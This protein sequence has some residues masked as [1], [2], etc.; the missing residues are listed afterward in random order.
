MF[1]L[2]V[3]RGL[4]R[5]KKNQIPHQLPGLWY[6]ALAGGPAGDLDFHIFP[7]IISEAEK[8][9]TKFSCGY[10]MEEKP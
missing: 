9:A 8:E 2:W 3:S 5:M 7:K 1:G 4:I 10:W 6:P